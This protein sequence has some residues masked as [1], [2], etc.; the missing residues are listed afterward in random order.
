MDT[1][2][3][4]GFKR[5]RRGTPQA[6]RRN[7]RI[8]TLAFF[9]ALVLP[10]SLLVWRVYDRLEID[11]SYRYRELADDLA[12][13]INKQVYDILDAE[14]K[15]PFGDYSF[16]RV[17]ES[18]LLNKK[19][20]SYSPLSELPPRSNLPGVVGYFQINPGGKLVSPVLPE[21]LD[22]SLKLANMGI[23]GVELSKRSAL[24]E[25]L[26]AS[27]EG[28]KLLSARRD[29]VGKDTF[30]KQRAG[31]WLP[32]KLSDVDLDTT[33][34]QAQRALPEQAAENV[35]MEQS[36]AR[37][38]SKRFEDLNIVSNAYN[39][40][41]FQNRREQV[42]DEPVKEE[43]LLNTDDQKAFFV[44][45]AEIDPLQMLVLD[46]GDFAFFRKIWT[47]G[48]RFVQ[49][50][51][52]RR[53]QFLQAAVGEL[54]QSSVLGRDALLA[55]VHDGSVIQQFSAPAESSRYARKSLPIKG[56]PGAMAK[57]VLFAK[58]RLYSPLDK[59]E[60]LFT[61]DKIATGPESKLVDALVV[62]LALVLIPGL[63]GI[64]RLG[65]CQ[66]AL[67]EKRSDFVSAVSHELKT[68]LTSIRMYGE[69]LR[70]GWVS[71][72]AKRKT[73]YD[74]IFFESERLSRLIGN[75]LQLA[76]ISRDDAALELK[77]FSPS[78]I[79]GL[80]HAKVQSQAEA[81]GFELDV[82]DGPEGNRER[83]TI[84]AEEDAISRIF[85]NLVDNAIKFSKDAE[86]KKV[87]LGYRFINTGARASVVF[88]VRDF[89]PGVPRA[90][91]RKI[92]ELFYR[93]ESELT[94]TTTGTG[95]GLALVREL[96]SKMGAEVD[97][98]DGDPG[99]E[100]QVKFP[101]NGLKDAATA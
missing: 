13:R 30:S 44:A 40:S 20:V 86:C 65:L 97:L 77:E 87:A 19:G 78:E 42:Q 93:V 29:A 49:G 31:S 8:A 51:V 55:L 92:F 79:L 96:A 26:E 39:N 10:L 89:G 28:T 32:Q 5:A 17:E 64:Y 70:S 27:L 73:Y 74:F 12:L 80:A 56:T 6:A 47:E 33:Q 58:S 46:N 41:L 76:K 67:A 53:E 61:V 37:E 11:A 35:Q 22:G 52:V 99:A 94:R 3:T 48:Q 38:K 21:T 68:P 69:M 7:L 95:I 84:L 59:V 81:Q 34:L 101:A 23:A 98:E 36:F 14:E 24:V 100:F 71:D 82:L 1:S 4:K 60:L 16:Y 83:V 50:F 91:K 15:R 66:I 75:I 25:E 90:E 43:S 18:K 45:G 63:Y 9:C 54:F 72:E 88:Y 85:I 57:A 62:I 2:R